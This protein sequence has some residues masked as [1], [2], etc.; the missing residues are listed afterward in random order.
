MPL[1]RGTRLKK[2][3]SARESRERTALKKVGRR[4]VACQPG[5]T[6]YWRL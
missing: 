2:R 6:E 4:S 3:F 1:N 5:V